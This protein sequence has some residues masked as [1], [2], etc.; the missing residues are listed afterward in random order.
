MLGPLLFILYTH[1]IWFGLENTLVAYADD[2]TLLVDVPSPD[3]RSVIPDSLYRDLAK[4]S[5]WCRSGLCGMEI[6][7]NKAQ[8]MIVRRS[9]NFQP[10]H[11]DLFIDN[12]PLST[13]DL[14]I[15]KLILAESSLLSLI[16]LFHVISRK[17][18]WLWKSLNF[19]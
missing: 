12:V 14:K 17:L 15:L 19:W 1:E 11:L 18:V 2:A 13:N 3:M 4:I 5:E 10:Q 16:F 6:N 7:P 8:S 9:R